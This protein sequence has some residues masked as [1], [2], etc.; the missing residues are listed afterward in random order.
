M[1]GRSRNPFQVAVRKLVTPAVA[2]EIVQV[3][4]ASALRG[5]PRAAGLIFGLLPRPS[6][7]LLADVKPITTA[8]EAADAMAQIT[9]DTVAGEIAAED[10]TQA[11][12]ALSLTGSTLIATRDLASLAA[13][14]AALR[15][16]VQ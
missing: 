16:L 5:S 12:A 13:E 11:L 4:V 2:E 7:P 6:F 1:C 9:T 14:I 3:M 8:Q 10:A 15:N